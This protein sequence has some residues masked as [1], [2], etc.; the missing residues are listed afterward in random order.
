MPTFPAR[1][2]AVL[3]YDVLGDGPP[4]LVL[5][6]GAAAHPSYLG[7]LAGLSDRHRLVVPHLRGVGGSAG[8]DLTRAGSRWAQA[9]DVDRLREHLGLARCTV[10]AH[11]AGTR[12]A[13]AHAAAHPERLAGL[14]LVTPPAEYL[15]DVPSDAPAIAA[16]R[17][18]AAFAEATAA[19]AGPPD[20]SGDEGFT[21]WRQASAALGYA[22]WDAT[23]RA[24]ARTLRYSLAA[25]RAFMTGD[26]PPDLTDRL[27]AVQAP[28][29]VVA[30]AQDAG[31][32]LAPVLA[33]AELFPHGRSVVVED[34]GHFPWVEQ[35]D[36]FRAAVDPFLAGVAG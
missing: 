28:V 32:G 13:V 8:A 20:L 1:D 7:D 12:L 10:L 2:G 18:D 5:A 21:A 34:C 9:D 35:P 29:L 4:V 25:A 15:V 30:G 6:G 14:V 36:A 17:H 31:T 24:H 26:G 22:R 16:A 11:S 19:A 23:T 27:R 3:S 33:V